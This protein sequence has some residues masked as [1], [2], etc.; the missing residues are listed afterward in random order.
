MAL[1]SIILKLY[2]YDGTSGSYTPND[3]K[4]TIEKNTIS[5]QSNI[6]VEVSELVRDYIE[7]NFDNDYSSVTKWVTA[8]V[9]YFDD[10]GDAYTYSNPQSFTFLATDGYGYFEDEINPELSRH[11]LYTSN[12]FYVP[13]ST[14]GKFPIFAEGVG[15]VT[16]DSTDTEITDSG[17]SNQ[18]I[19]YVTVPA[20]SSTIKIYDTDDTTLLKTV[21]VHNICEPKYTPYKLTYVNKYGAYQDLYF[22]KKSVESFDVSSEK[23]KV[24]T[25]NTSTVTY[26]TNATH[27]QLYN[28]NAKTK[29]KLNTGFVHEDFNSA[30]EEML[31]SENIWIRYENK[32]LPILPVTKNLTFKTS[33]NDKLVNYTIDFEFG[34]NKINNIR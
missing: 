14:A 17:N 33:V 8:I 20:D 27:S 16:I 4:Y 28:V 18:K 22:F 2:V 23:Y 31:L 10:N 11:A 29:I 12:H 21:T 19:Q 13:E 34:F 24:N 25:I 1:G 5:T 9:S 7:H 6:V 3:L 26:G 15:K 32:T 30:I